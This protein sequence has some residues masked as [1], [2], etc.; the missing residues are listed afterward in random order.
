MFHS[1]KRFAVCHLFSGNKLIVFT[2]IT[3]QEKRVLAKRTRDVRHVQSVCGTETCANSLLME[4]LA[5]A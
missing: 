3:S 4:A 2:Q 5:A 1:I